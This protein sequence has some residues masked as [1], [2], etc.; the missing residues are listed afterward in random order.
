MGSTVPTATARAVIRVMAIIPTPGVATTKL[1]GPYGF[2]I[3]STSGT[4]A[5]QINQN[6]I[7][8]I[9]NDQ[10]EFA[11]DAELA[12]SG[13]LPNSSR[14]SVQV[15]ASCSAGWSANTANN[16]VVFSEPGVNIQESTQGNQYLGQISQNGAVTINNVVPGTYRMTLYQLGQWGET[17]VD[18]VQVQNG[19]VT[20]PQNV[21]FTPENFGPSAPIW[22]IGTPNRSSNEFMNG[23]NAT[24]ADQRQYY[25]AYDFWAEEA[26]L[27]TPG[28]VVIQR[29]G[30]ELQWR[31]SAG[32]EQPERLDRQPVANLQSRTLRFEQRHDG[33]ILEDLPRLRDGRRGTGELS[34]IRLAGS[35]H[36][37]AV[38]VERRDSTSCCRWGWWRWTPAWLSR[39]TG[40]PRRGATTISRPDDPMIR[41]GDAGFYQWAAFQFP[42]SRP[43]R[44]RDQTDEFYLRRQLPYR[45]RHVRCAADGNHQYVGRSGGDRLARLHLHQRKLGHDAE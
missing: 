37:D 30:H 2:T 14:G 41:S 45:W 3:S 36:R 28:Y 4:T 19:Q 26:A 35:L 24:G 44:G 42:V 20:I 17:R 39:S 18:G 43:E 33:R 15:N 23:H 34:R 38:A 10:A 1:Y 25:G 12:A 27:G 7:N 9:P 5:A 21:K 8:A 13:Y 31:G 40:I 29:H 16:T 11:T 22:T 32:D 6:A